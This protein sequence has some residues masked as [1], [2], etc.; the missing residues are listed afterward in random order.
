MLQ[1]VEALHVVHQPHRLGDIKSFFAA[2]GVLVAQA[3]HRV[4]HLQPA[5]KLVQLREQVR[6][7]DLCREQVLQLLAHVRRH[8]VE[9]A[10]H[11][12]GLLL[13]LR[14]QLFQALRR[15]R[16]E[17]V[18]VLG[19]ERVEVRLVARDLLG[20]HLVQVFDHLL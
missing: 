11:L 7:G 13:H 6:V 16:L 18:A 4:E 1:L 17:Q 15:V 3:A 20:E 14:Y 12:A 8:A 5:G 2:E 9:H 19:H 10:L